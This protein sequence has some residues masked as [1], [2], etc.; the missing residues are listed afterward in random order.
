MVTQKELWLRR[1]GT[2]VVVS[3]YSVGTGIITAVAASGLAFLAPLA[4]PWLIAILIGVFLGETVVCIY[5]LKD[6]VPDTL[7]DL[8]LN[9]PF[10]DLSRPKQILLALGLF[11]ALG[12]GLAMGGLTYISGVTAIASAFA[13]IGIAAPPIALILIASLFAIIVFFAI[14][15]LLFKWISV[16]IK[17]D[18]HLQIR[19]FF[20]EIFTR[21]EKK[22]LAQQILEGTFKLLFTFAIVAITIVGTIAMLGSMNRG[23]LSLLALIPNANLLACTIASSIIAYALTGISRLPWALRSVCVVFAKLGE[24]VGY[25]F[26]CAGNFIV[27]ALNKL[28]L[29]TA[30]LNIQTIENE[31]IKVNPENEIVLAASNII[32]FLAMTIHG[33]C[34]GALAQNDGQV[35]SDIMTDLRFPLAPDAIQQT[36]EISATVADGIMAIGIAAFPLFSPPPPEPSASSQLAETSLEEL[37]LLTAT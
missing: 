16:A 18:F 19:D 15:T 14:A 33:L 23:L 35:L 25:A 10:A 2:W 6:T 9:D 34:L 27:H 26:F 37:P 3:G 1:L 31:E 17:K 24:M 21:D 4:L 30:T 28:M 32:K 13:V 5:L 29:P 8:L 36:G 20:K 12:A 11:S 7:V 22:F